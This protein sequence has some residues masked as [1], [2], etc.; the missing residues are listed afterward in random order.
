M[1]ICGYAQGIQCNVFP[2]HAQAAAVILSETMRMKELVDGILTI[3][4]L[5]SHDTRLRTEVISLGEFIEEQ[6]DILQG[7]GI[8]EKVSIGMEKEQED[9]RV[10]ADPSLLGKAF[11]NVV[12]NCARY[13]QSSVTVSLKR[14][15][16]WAA[17]CVKDDGP[18][19]DEKEI[20]HL[21]GQVGRGV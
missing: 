19:L 8:A 21:S 1:S 7:L 2:D 10:S 5:D 6:I 20:P 15:G 16:E 11:Q 12:N 14:E 9:I 17:V 4:R 18:G 3:S 13:A